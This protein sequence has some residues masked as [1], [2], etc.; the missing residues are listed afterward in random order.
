ML[1]SPAERPP[2]NT[3]GTV[4]SI[5]ERYGAD[6]LFFSPHIGRIGVQRKT[7]PDLIASLHDGRLA[8]EIP[9][10]QTLDM[11]VVVI[12]G[13]LEWTSD[14][15][16]YTQTASQLTKAQFLGICWSLFLNGLLP[17]FTCSQTETIRY[18]SLF[19]QWAQKERHTSLTSRSKT[20]AKNMYGTRES[21]DW[22]IHV[23]EGFPGIGYTR[24][25]TVVDFFG[26]LPLQWT[27]SLSD[28]PGIGQ[29]TAARLGKLLAPC[30][31]EDSDRTPT[32]ASEV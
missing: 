4:S 18:L 32:A 12:E 30:S 29:K 7:I 9:Q 17:A 16:L 1:V 11:G 25:A 13:T 8:K 27:G 31:T 22:Q 23:M 5:P 15:C 28:V 2:F 21:R 19:S 3:I 10:L 20:A 26:G 24:A 6:F 14:E